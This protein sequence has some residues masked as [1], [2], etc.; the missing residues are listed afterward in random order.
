MSLFK[1]PITQVLKLF[2][3][4]AVKQ[5]PPDRSVRIATIKTEIPLHSYASKINLS[6]KS[7]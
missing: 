2:S 5:E 3:A 6:F 7:D 1:H 4:L